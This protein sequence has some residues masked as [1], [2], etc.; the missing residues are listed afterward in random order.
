MNP[1]IEKQAGF[2]RYLYKFVITSAILVLN[3]SP[4]IHSRYICRP[5]KVST[6][7]EGGCCVPLRP[8]FVQNRR[9][10]EVL[11]K[12]DEGGHQGAASLTMMP[13]CV[14]SCYSYGEHSII[15]GYT[16]AC[17]LPCIFETATSSDRANTPVS[18]P[19]PS[20]SG[21]RSQ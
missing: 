20:I 7:E 5:R 18:H 14:K 3:H 15:L 1:E 21:E 12:M 4:W 9:G 16:R 17:N 19:T 6:T 2:G 10:S 13:P 11:A 8:I